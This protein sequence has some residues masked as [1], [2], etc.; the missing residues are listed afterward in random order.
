M[1]YMKYS[2]S[3][4]YT[5]AEM[6]E[7]YLLK[8][9]KHRMKK[10]E[11]FTRA[12]ELEKCYNY[13]ADNLNSFLFADSTHMKE[14]LAAAYKCKAYKNSELEAYERNAAKYICDQLDDI[15]AMINHEPEKYE[16][17]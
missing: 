14:L 6:V 2:R 13:A 12:C 1:E 7:K 9:Q 5:C 3:E 16:K 10:A 4:L 11:F 15:L 8:W 17:F